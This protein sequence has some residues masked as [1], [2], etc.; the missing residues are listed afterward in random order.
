MRNGKK[1]IRVTELERQLAKA[2]RIAR[3]HYRA[4]IEGRK[5]AEWAQE[6]W[7]DDHPWLKDRD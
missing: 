7:E 2:R 6:M 5:L 4:R 1:S 3:Y